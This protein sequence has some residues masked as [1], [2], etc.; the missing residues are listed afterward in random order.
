MLFKF[1]VLQQIFEPDAEFLFIPG[2]QNL[3]IG[4][5]FK[6]YFYNLINLQFSVL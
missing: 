1:F 6:S 5:S 2:F 3:F 4:L